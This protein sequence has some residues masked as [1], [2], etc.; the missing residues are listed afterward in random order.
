MQPG[1]RWAGPGAAPS[2]DHALSPA[3]CSCLHPCS[4]AA[5]QLTWLVIQSTSGGAAASALNAMEL[6]DKL[7]ACGEPMRCCA[8]LPFRRM[9]AR[10]CRAARRRAWYVVGRGTWHP[11]RPLPCTLPPLADRAGAS[12]ASLPRDEDRES[13]AAIAASCGSRGDAEDLVADIVRG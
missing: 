8:G 12:N 11:P 5:D 9:R 13:F 4:Y 2:S 1:D 7:N 3:P 10:A 6:Q